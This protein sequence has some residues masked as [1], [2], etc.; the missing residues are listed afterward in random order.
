MI[1]YLVRPRL[2]SNS[3]FNF[4][5]VMQSPHLSLLIFKI[6]T[7]E[8]QSDLRVIDSTL[9]FRA[10]WHSFGGFH[11]LIYLWPYLISRDKICGNICI[12]NHNI[13]SFCFLHRLLKALFTTFAFALAALLLLYLIIDLNSLLTELNHPSSGGLMV[14]I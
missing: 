13:F 1:G 5:L 7:F 2:Y 14:S 9:K 10:F 11:S 4:F 8:R 3:S 6:N 12:L